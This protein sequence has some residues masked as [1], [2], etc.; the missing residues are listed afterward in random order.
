MLR[1]MLPVLSSPMLHPHS[2]AVA[3]RWSVF[4]IAI[5]AERSSGCHHNGQRT[6][7]H[8][9]DQLSSHPSP[10]SA[11]ETDRIRHGGLCAQDD[12]EVWRGCK[13]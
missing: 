9:D 3:S 2:A 6:Q 10:A 5:V 12:G 13:V 7:R 1:L 8:P 4:R 11:S